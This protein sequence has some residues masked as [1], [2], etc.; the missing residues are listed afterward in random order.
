MGLDTKLLTYTASYTSSAVDGGEGVVVVAV[1]P[2]FSRLR[3]TER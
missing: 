1:R 3:L 2:L